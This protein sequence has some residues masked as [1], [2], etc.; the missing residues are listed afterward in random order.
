MGVRI[1]AD[2]ALTS[3]GERTPFAGLQLGALLGRGSYGR[4]YKGYHRGR[5]IAV[6]ARCAAHG[7]HLSPSSTDTIGASGIASSLAG[8][9]G[10]LPGCCAPSAREPSLRRSA[11]QASRGRPWVRVVCERWC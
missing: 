9:G 11:L 8:G 10:S 1:E 4:V 2:A 3:A 6:K 5:V 7:L